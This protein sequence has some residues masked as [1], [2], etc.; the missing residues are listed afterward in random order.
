MDKVI[1][2]KITQAT[3]WHMCK[4]C[5]T[6]LLTSIDMVGSAAGKTKSNILISFS[7]VSAISSLRKVV[8]VQIFG[9]TNV[10]RVWSRY[11]D[12]LALKKMSK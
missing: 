7:V 2:K 9:Q 11:F 10:S 4:S 5:V 12:Q 6:Y 3:Y 8:K 1:T